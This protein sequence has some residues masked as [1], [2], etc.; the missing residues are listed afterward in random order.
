L[1][2]DVEHDEIRLRERDRFSSDGAIFTDH[3]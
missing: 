1:A 3:G 2:V